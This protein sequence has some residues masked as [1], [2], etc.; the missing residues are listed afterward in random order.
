MR[1]RAGDCAAGVPQPADAAGG[2]HGGVISA[3]GLI[4][5]ATFA[6]LAVMPPLSLAQI[7]GI[8]AHGVLIGTLLV[9]LFLGPALILGLGHRTWWPVRLS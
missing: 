4:L 5:A 9:R 3:A 6:A 8:V 7:W 1:R 2:D